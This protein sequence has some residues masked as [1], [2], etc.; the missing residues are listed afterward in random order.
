MPGATFTE[1]HQKSKS[2]KLFQKPVVPALQEAG[3]DAKDIS[4][5][6]APV[7]VDPAFKNSI[8]NK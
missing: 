4:D 6:F 8:I 3:V 2:R 7:V 1:G 5:C